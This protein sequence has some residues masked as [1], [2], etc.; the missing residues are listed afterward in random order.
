MLSLILMRC[1][2]VSTLVGVVGLLNTSVATAFKSTD[3]DVESSLPE[4]SENSAATDP[5]PTDGDTAGI[6]ALILT[7]LQDDIDYHISDNPSV[8]QSITES[9]LQDTTVDSSESDQL[10]QVTPTSQIVETQPVEEQPALS[11]EAVP[12]NEI[13][14]TNSTDLLGSGALDQLTSVTQLSDVQP[15]DWAYQALQSLSGVPQTCHPASAGFCPS[16]DAV[17]ARH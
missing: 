1:L 13:G 4:S 6:D 14:S 3:V 10:S 12:G 5:A 16:R 15:T 8:S 2:F 17:G 9:T 11:N 7:N